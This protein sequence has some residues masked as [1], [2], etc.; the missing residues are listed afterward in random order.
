LTINQVCK[1]KYLEKTKP[2]LH[3]KVKEL[4]GSWREKL[5]EEENKVA[6]DK[7]KEEGASS[8]ESFLEYAGR[9]I[10]L[11]QRV[12]ER[13]LT[14]IVD[15]NRANAVETIVK[16]F[17][18]TELKAKLLERG[19]KVD[20]TIRNVLDLALRIEGAI[21]YHSY[22]KHNYVKEV[23]DRI[24][25]LSHK[26]S[27]NL[28]FELFEELLSPEEFATK[29]T[30]E[31]EPDDIKKRLQLGKDWYMKSLQSD[32]YMKHTDY[33]EGEITCYKC[34]GK[35]VFTAQKQMKAADEPMTT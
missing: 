29:D 13:A 33:K 14:R 28:K 20:F 35:K 9:F 17:F 18:S 27:I 12:V 22:K 3:S 8:S 25:L 1:N 15:K 11:D 19:S 4:K 24:L 2:E 16:Q 10:S 32:F 26:K 31:L 5:I 34:R 30:Q 7:V 6:I 21:Y 23:R